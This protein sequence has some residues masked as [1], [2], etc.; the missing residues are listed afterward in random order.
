MVVDVGGDVSWVGGR[1][2]Q[3]LQL[4]EVVV[5]QV[6]NGPDR[7]EITF[8]GTADTESY[9]P[10]GT[11]E[12]EFG[13]QGGASTTK[14][15]SGEIVGL[16]A[17]YRET[18]GTGGLVLR[19][20][21]ATAALQD[22]R[23]TKTWWD[24]KDSDL[25]SEIAGQYSLE[26]DTDDTKFVNPYIIQNNETDLEFLYR[27][28]GR[29]G[30]EVDCKDG[31]LTFAPPRIEAPVAAFGPED[32]EGFDFEIATPQRVA[33]VWAQ[34][35]DPETGRRFVAT[36]G[37]AE[38]RGLGAPAHRQPD[39]ADGFYDFKRI[40]VVDPVF[41]QEEIDAIAKGL[42]DRTDGSVVLRAT[43]AA[44]PGIEAGSTI[45]VDTEDPRTTGLYRVLHARH[46]I[47]AD[48]G[49]TTWIRAVRVE[50]GSGS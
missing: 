6:Q 30:Y 33:Q 7:C 43:L 23:D 22:N 40:V 39:D 50:D 20:A 42:Y 24:I 12:I 13:Y 19:G 34:G 49:H 29:I 45:A 35:R 21:D 44:T 48:Q 37:D 2:A 5:D 46:R 14:V 41:S 17:I 26:A 15:F 10:G 28:A 4:L 47:S 3:G 32:V 8:N 9:E 25:V 16:E 1:S 31:V 38:V 36:V 18:A 11:V 27:R